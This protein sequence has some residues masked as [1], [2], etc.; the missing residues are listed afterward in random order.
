M[1]SVLFTSKERL[2]VQRRRRSAA[3]ITSR[4]P[5]PSSRRRSSSSISWAPVTLRFLVSGWP[6]ATT[7]S[8]SSS[9]HGRNLEPTVVDR[10]LD[11]PELHLVLQHR[12]DDGAG[13]G[14]EELEVD[15]GMGPVQLTED[16]RQEI[17][18][19][20]GAGADA[21]HAIAE[22]AERLQPLLGGALLGEERPG[23]LEQ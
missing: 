22:P 16:R 10:T 8:S 23:V 5:A 17:R 7:T 12:A 3:S 14:G 19:Q 15:P 2:G 9:R 20:R 1:A 13:V 4:V 18:G 11:E 6:G 21:Q